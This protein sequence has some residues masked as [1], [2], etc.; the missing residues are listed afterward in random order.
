VAAVIEVHT[1][2]KGGL[3][4]PRVDIAVDCGLAAH[5]DRVT[6]QMEGATIMGLGLALSGQITFS[7]GRV[8]QQNFSDYEV[9]RID[10]AP[11][12]IHV[13]IVPSTEVPGGVGEPGL[14]PIA[15]AFCNAIF[16]ATG[17]RI[18]QLPIARQLQS[19]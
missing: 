6:S 5:P 4:V 7:K 3:T 14:P 10:A 19:A 1:D 11:R 8:D 2:G 17:K 15:P 13:H 9:L 16:A 18:R 12:E